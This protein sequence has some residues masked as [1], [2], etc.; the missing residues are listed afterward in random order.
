MDYQYT[1][2]IKCFQPPIK[3]RSKKL[4]KQHMYWGFKTDATS[5]E[6]SMC[7]EVSKL[8]HDQSTV[9]IKQDQNKQVDVI[10][11]PGFESPIDMSKSNVFSHPYKSEVYLMTRC[12]KLWK[13]AHVL[14]FQNSVMN[15]R[16][17]GHSYPKKQQKYENVISWPD[18]ISYENSMCIE[19]SKLSQ[20][21]SIVR[22]HPPIKRELWT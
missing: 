19:V 8:S 3:I 10:A 1:C 4:W 5:Y 14:S 22:S 17:S 20:D 2:Q 21:K 9:A 15:G 13:T 7:I 18:A 11:W 16:Y 12:N 6:N